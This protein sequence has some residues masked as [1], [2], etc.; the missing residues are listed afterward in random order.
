MF[1]LHCVAR[2]PIVTGSQKWLKPKLVRKY[3]ENHL[4]R[5]KHD[6]GDPLGSNPME[7]RGEF[8]VVAIQLDGASRDMVQKAES[9]KQ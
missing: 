3:H 2:P 6:D 7:A 5:P 1:Y 8:F 4:D 9:D